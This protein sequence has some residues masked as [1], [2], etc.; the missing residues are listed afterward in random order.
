M[1]NKRNICPI[2]IPLLRA[3]IQKLW[4]S[5]SEGP[6]FALGGINAVIKPVTK[7]PC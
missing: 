5:P 4:A 3:D 6:E 7:P 1:R 2:A